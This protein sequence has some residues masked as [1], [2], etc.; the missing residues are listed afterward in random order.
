MTE[1]GR[2]MPQIVV[3]LAVRMVLHMYSATAAH[4]SIPL[5][6]LFSYDCAKGAL[7]SL[8]AATSPETASANGKVISSR[9]RQ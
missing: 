9:F 1:L 7:T 6:G 5:Q 2:T 8:Y 3:K 4:S